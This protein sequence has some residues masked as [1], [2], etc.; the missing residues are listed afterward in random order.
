MQRSTTRMHTLMLH[1]GE[2]DLQQSAMQAELETTAT[3]ESTAVA[4]EEC[5]SSTCCMRAALARFCHRCILSAF[6]STISLQWH[7]EL[8]L[9]SLILFIRSSVRLNLWWLADT[10]MVAR[11]VAHGVAAGVTRGTATGVVARATGA[12]A[13]QARK[14]FQIRIIAIQPLLCPR[15]ARDH[16]YIRRSIPTCPTS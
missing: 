8:Q 12:A 10:R 4:Q 3:S 13:R 5:G 9:K 14:V 7:S 16:M 15:P 2:G 11:G 6:R 1:S